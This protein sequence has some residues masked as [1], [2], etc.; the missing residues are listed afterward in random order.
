MSLPTKTKQWILINKPTDLPV[1]EGD[2]AT[3]AFETKDIQAL[4]DDEVL[5]Q[6]LYLSNDPAQR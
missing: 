2:E 4:Q 5:L 3:F 1:F 6:T